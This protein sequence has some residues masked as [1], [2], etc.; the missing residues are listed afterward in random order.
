MWAIQHHD[1]MLKIE[2][3]A[4]TNLNLMALSHTVLTPQGRELAAFCIHQP[5][6]QYLSLFAGW[7]LAERDCTLSMAPINSK[8][9][10]GMIHYYENTVRIIE[11]AKPS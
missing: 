3:P 8:D 1:H 5:N 2:G 4:N 9:A 7:L 10:S 11:P 6:S